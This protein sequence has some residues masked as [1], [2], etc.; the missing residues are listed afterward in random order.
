MEITYEQFVKCCPVAA[1]PDHDVFDAIQELIQGRLRYIYSL[2]PEARL[3][4]IEAEAEQYDLEIDETKYV[5]QRDFIRAVRMYV[6]SKALWLAVPHLDLVLTPTGFG[7]VSTQ[8]VAPA[9]AERVAN[10]RNTLS[11]T[12]DS[13]FDNMLDYGRSLVNWRATA[14]GRELF[15]SLFWR[16]GHVRFFGVANASRDELAV[17]MPD[18][19]IAAEALK[20]A[21]S[22]EQYDALLAIEASDC[23]TEAQEQ[24]IALSHF[25]TVAW[26]QDRRRFHALRDDMIRIIESKP[27]DFPAYMNSATYVA[28]H[29]DAYENKKDDSCFFFG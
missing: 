1:A 27:E 21:Y 10:L 6:C 26:L 24:I 7:V 23:A 12:A 19:E 29:S 2:V 8:N 18:I 11:H 25:A 22:P 5:R 14:R 3:A 20:R 28:N 17:R 9:S 13:A 4:E 16:G 15:R